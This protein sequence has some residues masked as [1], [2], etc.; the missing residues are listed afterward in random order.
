MI[1]IIPITLCQSYLGLEIMTDYWTYKPQLIP[2]FVFQP[3]LTIMRDYCQR[4]NNRKRHSCVFVDIHS[5]VTSVTKE[6][7]YNHIPLYR[8]QHAPSI[9]HEVCKIIE[10]QTA[11]NYDYV[12]VHIYE[13]GEAGIGWHNDKE[14]LNSSIA[15]LSLGA[16]R[17]FR[18]K[19][20]GRKTGWDH[21]FSL[22]DGDMIWMHGP[23]PTTGR[24]SCQKI[25]LH[26][27]PV[28]KKVKG[29]RINLT[30]RQY[31]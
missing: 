26:T 13:S 11:E 31:E 15:S 4:G 27:V 8:W 25:Y 9:L 10:D 5:P 6:I 2:S 18:L 7:G 20:I 17:K 29:P 28:E 1:F 3:L 24:E 12:L 16:T 14:A 23:D 19:K 21:E 30:F 22:K